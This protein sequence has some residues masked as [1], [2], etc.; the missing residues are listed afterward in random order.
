[1]LN[2]DIK[3]FY[4]E[5]NIASGSW[6]NVYKASYNHTNNAS[7]KPHKKSVVAIKAVNVH[8]F[9][10]YKFNEITKC[11]KREA[12]IH[13]ELSHPNIVKLY[14]YID[15]INENGYFYFIMEY[16][17]SVD[18]FQLT[19][20]HVLS[21]IQITN[22]M[23][24]TIDALSYCH[25]QLIMHRDIKLENIIYSRHKNIVKLVD[26]GLS[27][28]FAKPLDSQNYGNCG[29]PEYQAY[30]MVCDYSYDERVDIWALG[31]VLYELEIGDTPFISDSFK[32]IENNIKT[33]KI[34]KPYCDPTRFSFAYFDIK[35]QIIK[36]MLDRNPDTRISLSKLGKRLNYLK[37]Q[38]QNTD[39]L[40]LQTSESSEKK[41]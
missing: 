37:L 11:V 8:K 2:Q 5:E 39:S 34:S 36:S 4:F 23:L 21:D 1:M 19:S 38:I 35:W 29:T 28:K 25:S 24:Q 22:I 9:T 17:D 13:R 27:I 7:D 15:N 40:N 33:L 3:H 16:I 20:N 12:N 30:E 31:V 41:S 26:F 32:G 10:N 6:G 18:L 14:T